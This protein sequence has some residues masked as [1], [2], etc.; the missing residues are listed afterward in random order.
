[1]AVISAI[2]LAIWELLKSFPKGLE[3][4]VLSPPNIRNVYLAWLNA[5]FNCWAE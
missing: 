4:I 1:M 2:I 5:S 3:H